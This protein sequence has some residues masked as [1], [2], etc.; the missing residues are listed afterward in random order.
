AGIELPVK[1]YRRQVFMTEAF[2]IIP[3]PVPM[4]IDSDAYFYLRGEEPGILMG[5]SDLKEPS[6]FNTNVGRG[7]LERLIEVA[8]HR[9]PVL[10]KAKILRGW[11]GL[12]TITPDENPIIGEIPELR[13]FFCAI[14]FSGHGFQHGPA[15]G[16]ILSQL[17]MKEDPQF[18][19]DSFSYNRFEKPKKN[20][21]KRVV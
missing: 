20:G 18:D 8:I 4:I 21:E 15:I 19:L 17:V 12:Y 5:M 1:P 14:G 3:K 13:G 10:E 9:T 11:G 2:D 6:S 16:R 7:F